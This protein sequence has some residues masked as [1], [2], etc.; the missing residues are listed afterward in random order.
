MSAAWL[1][2][3]RCPPSSC[4]WWH[5]ALRDWP[6]T[7]PTLDPPTGSWERSWV[8]VPVWLRDGRCSGPIYALRWSA[9]APAVSSARIS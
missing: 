2:C 8:R 4:C 9:S 7:I 3:S 1:Q 6:A 5:G